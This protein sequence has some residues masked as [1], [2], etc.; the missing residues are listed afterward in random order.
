MALTLEEMAVKFS[1]DGDAAVVQSFNNI[2]TA[3]NKTRQTVTQNFE[4]TAT[5]SKGAVKK[6][7]N[8]GIQLAFIFATMANDGKISF[9]TLLQ[10]ISSLGFAFGPVVGI[11]TT[12]A[13]S[14]GSALISMFQKTREE[15]EKTK[16]A[17]IDV[18]R[19]IAASGSL[20]QAA[21]RQQQLFSGGIVTGE[22]TTDKL[23]RAGGLI[24]Q[25]RKMAELQK[26]RDAIIA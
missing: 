16:Q 23:I 10:G 9:Q 11:I 19:Q 21:L 18:S 3:S 7:E 5:L 20:A 6:M 17:M 12:A 1:S 8:L 24:E 13:G 4:Q 22:G 15:A 14:I 2:G 26:Q 25:Q